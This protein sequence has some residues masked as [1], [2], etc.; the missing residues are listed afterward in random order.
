MMTYKKSFNYNIIYISGY[1]IL[2]GTQANLTNVLCMSDALDKKINNLF[3]ILFVPFSNLFETKTILRGIDKDL[4]VSIIPIP[5]LKIRGIYL[6]FDFLSFLI[7]IPF[8][9]FGFDIYTRNQ[10]L[11]RFIYSIKKDIYIELHDL[12]KS[13]LKCLKTCKKA[14]FLS[15]SK[16]I[17]KDIA[18]TKLGRKLYLLP[19][20]AKISK[21]LNKEL[22]PKFK[23][24]AIGYIGSNNKG[25]GVN[26]IIKLSK[27]D[28]NINYYLAGFIKIENTPSNIYLLGMLNKHQIR[29]MVE[30]VDIFIAPYEKL[31]FDNAG[32]NISNYMSPLKIFEYMSSKKPF[33]VSRLN[34]VEEFLDEEIDCLM[35]SPDDLKDWI[36]KIKKLLSDEILCK[37]LSDNSYQKYLS[38]YTWEIRAENLLK[39]IKKNKKINLT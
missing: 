11:A 31:V 22:I 18:N 7:L 6:F 19:D 28:Q 36:F 39:I 3:L 21:K 38:F 8:I 10:R 32:N 23:K 30:K 1:S 2:T 25:K 14:I 9:I 4:K 27:I 20:A 16:S 17:I 37:K 33:I 34:F 26:N 35:S 15:I 5:Y 13:S 29:E 12:S 24:P